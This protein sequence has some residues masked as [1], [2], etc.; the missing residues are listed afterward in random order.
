VIN[1]QEKQKKFFQK[2]LFPRNRYIKQKELDIIIKVQK[3]ILKRLKR[4]QE[5]VKDSWNI[6]KE[7]EKID[8]TRS[9]KFGLLT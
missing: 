5:W 9:M 2:Q 8:Y 3:D 1:I 4:I 6:L 7:F